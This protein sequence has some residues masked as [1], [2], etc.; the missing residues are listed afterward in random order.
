MTHMSRRTRRQL[1]S[2]VRSTC[3]RPAPSCVCR[4]GPLPSRPLPHGAERATRGATA[5]A[6]AW[7]CTLQHPAAPCSTV[8]ICEEC[9]IP[10][11]ERRGSAKVRTASRP[12][13]HT[14][15]G[16]PLP[17]P[18]SHG[19]SALRRTARRAAR[20]T[21]PC[22]SSHQD[23]SPAPVNRPRFHL[24]ARFG[25]LPGQRRGTHL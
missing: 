7:V 1:M 8:V 20:S 4:P 5:Y 2:A 9:T 3:V 6:A 11:F 16:S 12:R 19:C 15:R 17:P 13:Q 18:T 23:V 24:S 21:N 14:K 25:P 10:R 22:G